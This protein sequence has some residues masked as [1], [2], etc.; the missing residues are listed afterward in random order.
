FDAIQKETD[1]F[2]RL[3]WLIERQEN[4]LQQCGRQ[5][6]LPR[7]LGLSDHIAL[8]KDCEHVLRDYYETRCDP[9]FPRQLIQDGL[10]PK[11]RQTFIDVLGEE[12]GEENYGLTFNE[13]Q[14][15]DAIDGWLG[16]RQA[17]LAVRRPV[18]GLS[19]ALS[20]MEQAQRKLAEPGLSRADILG[21]VTDAFVLGETLLRQMLSFYGR[22]FYGSRYVDRIL[23]QYDQ[24]TRAR[25]APGVASLPEL[26][27]ELVEFFSLR[28]EEREKAVRDF[29]EALLR[30]R[31]VKYPPT[32]AGKL[33]DWHEKGKGLGFLGWTEVLHSLDRWVVHAF[34]DP[35]TNE[36]RERGQNFERLFRR[37]RLFPSRLEAGRTVNV[38][39]KESNR[40]EIKTIPIERMDT[41]PFIEILRYLNRVRPLYVHEA[42]PDFMHP[43]NRENMHDGARKI[44]DVF[45]KLW[46]EA[47]GVVFPPVVLVR[48]LLQ[49][50]PNLI[51]LDYVPESGA[52]LECIR[53]IL[54]DLPPYAPRLLGQEAY[55]YTWKGQDSIILALFAVDE[56]LEV[57]E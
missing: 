8:L 16:F 2:R 32:E 3:A 44:L 47:Q 21:Q 14:I 53:V 29:L 36:E 28:E 25:G 52:S 22:V 19:V 57:V 17:A 20:Q 55:L 26:S 51:R 11:V 49:I 31:K 4:Y 9:G 42:D 56:E 37:K 35:Q 46:T 18:N 41:S 50:E 43:S 10:T 45:V 15:L 54:R 27:A 39:V 34:D 7:I 30:G 5:S 48:R 23:Q 40:I 6:E 1:P 13:D 33:R 24:E 38:P 12:R